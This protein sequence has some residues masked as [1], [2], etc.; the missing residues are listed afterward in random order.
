MLASVVQM[1]FPS[2]SSAPLKVKRATSA[3]PSDHPALDWPPCARDAARQLSCSSSAN[4][5]SET[6]FIGDLSAAGAEVS[7]KPDPDGRLVRRPQGR[8]TA[9]LTKSATKGQICDS[10]TWT[11]SRLRDRIEYELQLSRAVGPFYG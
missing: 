6:G 10:Y 8:R 2:A 7:T 5:L 4:S 1:R 9:D 11:T 3:A